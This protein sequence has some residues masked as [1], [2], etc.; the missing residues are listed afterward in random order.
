M[1]GV[2]PLEAEREKGKIFL[3]AGPKPALLGG[4]DIRPRLKS[5][6]FSARWRAPAQWLRAGGCLL[7]VVVTGEAPVRGRGVSSAGE[8][9]GR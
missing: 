1:L 6:V 4:D 8:G 5:S 7:V 2:N 3:R 9:G